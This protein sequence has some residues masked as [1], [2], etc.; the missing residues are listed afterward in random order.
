MCVRY[1]DGSND[2]C[3]PRFILPYFRQVLYSGQ[4]AYVMREL[5]LVGRMDWIYRPR[6][7]RLPHI[8]HVPFSLICIQVKP[9][10]MLCAGIQ[11]DV[12]CHVPSMS[13]STAQDNPLDQ[14]KTPV[15]A[16]D[17]LLSDPIGM[18]GATDLHEQGIVHTIIPRHPSSLG[19]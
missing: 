7:A 6:S 3:V 17:A 5:G 19:K 18:S 15:H 1:K 14:E 10:S 4:C 13:V 8:T 11:L 12:P 2:P 16:F 9:L